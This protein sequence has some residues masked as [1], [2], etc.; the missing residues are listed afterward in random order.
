MQFTESRIR[1]ITT[2][3]IN[4]CEFHGFPDKYG[5][6]LSNYWNTLEA[7]QEWKE[8]L[9]REY[10]EKDVPIVL[11]EITSWEILE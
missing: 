11:K 9:E 1:Y 5:K 6:G 4:G 10:S 7:S 2:V 8:K 3:L